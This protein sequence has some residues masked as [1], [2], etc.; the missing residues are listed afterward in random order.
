MWRKEIN[1]KNCLGKIVCS[2]FSY[3]RIDRFEGKR[4]ISTTAYD[5]LYSLSIKYNPLPER[6]IQEID[7][8]T[9]PIVISKIHREINFD[10]YH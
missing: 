1:S 4:S 5:F 3:D 2:R 9:F 6:S 7:Y 10:H 8:S